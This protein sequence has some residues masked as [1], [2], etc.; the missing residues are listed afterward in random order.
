MAGIPAATLDHET[1]LS[2][3]GRS[4]CRGTA[5][6]NPTRTHGVAGSIAGLVQWVKDQSIAVSC[7][8]GHRLG[9][10]LVLLWLWHR[11]AAVA[12]MRPLA[13]EPPYTVGMAL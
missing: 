4:S 7:G 9:S 3:E 1:N 13:W 5:E 2:M 8:V 11:P 6:T 10:D 12:L